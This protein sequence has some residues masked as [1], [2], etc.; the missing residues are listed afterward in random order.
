MRMGGDAFPST[1]RLSEAEYQRVVE[2]ILVVVE[3][4]GVRAR[5]PV[6]V[7]DKAELCLARG[8]DRPYGDVDILLALEDRDAQ[9]E[10]V[11]IVCKDLGSQG[12]VLKNNTTYSFLTSERYQVDLEFCAPKNFFFKLAFK[13]NNDFGALLGHLLTPLKLKWSEAGLGLRL[14]VQGVPGIGTRHADLVL[15]NNLHTV[16][17]FIGL[18]TIALD[19]VTRLS[20]QQMFEILTTSRVFFLCDYDEKYKIKER[21]KKRPVSDAFF[22]MVEEQ[23]EHLEKRKREMYKNDKL[24]SLFHEFRSKDVEFENFALQVADYF[25]KADEVP[26]LLLEMK[27]PDKSKVNCKFSFYTLEQWLP[28]S[29]QK[30]LG[31]VMQKLKCRY[32]GE[33]GKAAFEAWIENTPLESIRQAAMQEAAYL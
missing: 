25:G 26:K 9:Q 14:K 31:R 29:D 30:T 32:S 28:E 4:R 8:K 5:P 16:C 24:E 33:V 2:R 21:R 12:E 17:D 15:T 22:N 18:P 11:R 1:Q 27:T 23:E 6:E 3:D 13:S 7:A 10:L 19:G 20:I